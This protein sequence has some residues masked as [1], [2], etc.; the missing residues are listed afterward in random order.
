MYSKIKITSK[1]FAKPD[2]N[3]ISLLII[4]HIENI[5]RDLKTDIK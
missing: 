4:S 2:N 1:I 5:H 3:T